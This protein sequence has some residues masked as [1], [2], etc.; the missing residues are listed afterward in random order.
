MISLIRSA[1]VLNRVTVTSG[2]LRAMSSTSYLVEQEKFGFLKD[3]GLQKINKGVYNGEWTGNGE[4]NNF[5]N[6]KFS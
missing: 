3:L 4:V 6:L 2:I 5:L 1:A